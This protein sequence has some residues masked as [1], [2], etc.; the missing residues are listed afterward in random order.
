[1]ADHASGLATKAALVGV[2]NLWSRLAERAFGKIFTSASYT[3]CH[4]SPNSTSLLLM[5][6]PLAA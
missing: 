5:H 6:A 3:K 4:H 1:M 2:A